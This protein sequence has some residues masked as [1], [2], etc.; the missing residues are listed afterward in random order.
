MLRSWTH[1]EDYFL[2]LRYCVPRV[3]GITW[4]P[5][6]CCEFVIYLK[7]FI[8]ILL[9]LFHLH[10]SL[11]CYPDQHQLHISEDES[12]SSKYSQH[13]SSYFLSALMQV[14]INFRRKSELS[15]KT[16]SF[17]CVNWIQNST[18]YSPALFYVVIY[19]IVIY[20]AGNSRYTADMSSLNL[21][22]SAES[23]HSGVQISL[24]EPVVTHQGTEWFF[25]QSWFFAC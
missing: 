17:V 10:W 21:W 3:P 7:P 5:K 20:K 25:H 16:T 2:I 18:E 22:R 13:F 19:F 4:S 11:R 12:T 1:S 23:K 6:I 24:E 14:K 15:C 8:L 9:S